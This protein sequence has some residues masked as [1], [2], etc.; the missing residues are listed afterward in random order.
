MKDV[1]NAAWRLFG[2]TQVNAHRAAV[3][4]VAVT[5]TALPW[6]GDAS[7]RAKDLKMG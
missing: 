7:E 6:D 5:I 3:G 1:D 4:E 2:R